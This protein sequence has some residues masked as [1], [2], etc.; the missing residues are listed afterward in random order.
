M[1]RLIKYFYKHGCNNRDVVTILLQNQM[2]S[3]GSVDSYDEG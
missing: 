1:V 3:N 2:N